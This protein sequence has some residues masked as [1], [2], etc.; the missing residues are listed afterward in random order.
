[1]ELQQV[2]YG[3]H[4]MCYASTMEEAASKLAVDYARYV[5]LWWWSLFQ[6]CCESGLFVNN[7]DLLPNAAVPDEFKKAFWYVGRR[8]G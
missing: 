8:P 3:L 1:M 7:D 5:F 4:D 6:V 2:K